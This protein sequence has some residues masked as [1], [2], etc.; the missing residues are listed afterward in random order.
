LIFKCSGGGS[1]YDDDDDDDDDMVV[2]IGVPGVAGTRSA[3]QA[4]P[5][6]AK[7]ARN[8]NSD[9]VHSFSSE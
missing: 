2:P 8:L 4:T 1:S 5:V 7:V 6:A 9:D 3:E